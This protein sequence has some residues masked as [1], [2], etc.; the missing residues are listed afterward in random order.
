MTPVDPTVSVVDAVGEEG[1]GHARRLFRAY[2]AEYTTSIAESLCF[3]G[4]E[5]ELAGLPGRYAPPSGCL[6]LAMEG[7]QPAG[8]VAMRDLGGGTCEMK[9]LYV[10][11]E[12]RG[13]GVGRLLVEVVLQRAERAG[14][15]R[16]VLDTLPEMAGALALYREFGFVEAVPYWDCP[17]ER[18]V[19]LERRLDVTDGN[20]ATS[21]ATVVQDDLAAYFEHLA[22]R[23]ERLVGM[24]THEQV[25]SNPFGF[26]NSVGRI[27]VHLTGSL[28]HFIG[29]KVAGTSYVRDRPLEFADPAC[30]P[31][32]ELL[33]RFREAIGLVVRTLRSQGEAGLTALLDDCGEP[34]R[35][36]FGLFLVCAAHVANHAGQIVYLVQAHGH[37]LDEKVW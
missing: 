24:L 8:C 35:D 19:Y 12:H 34:V 4:F 29:A 31:A 7:D 26:G 17:V 1:L 21:L 22:A 5:A 25:W 6:L 18:T 23:I 3:Q 32:D 33:G 27:V 2:A 11:P 10:A 36:R 14:Y 16:M 13:R 15:D 28:S 20:D 9:R 37:R 30:P